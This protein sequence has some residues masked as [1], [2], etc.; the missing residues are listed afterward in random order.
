MT[1][2]PPRNLRLHLAVLGA[3]AVGLAAVAGSA[4]ELYGVGQTI[5]Y[6]WPA[7]IPLALDG[8]AVV[9]TALVTLR[10]DRHALA[11]LVA[12]GVLS[13]ALQVGAVLLPLL[14]REITMAAAAVAGLSILV[15]LAV[16]GAAITA[17]HLVAR[18]TA[19]DA[20]PAPAEASPVVPEPVAPPAPVEPAPILAPAPEPAPV[21]LAASAEVRPTP[22]RRPPRPRTDTA[23][24]RPRTRTLEELVPIAE[25]V[26]GDLQERGLPLSRRNL[27]DG[28]KDAGA[29]VGTTR[30]TELLE[31]LQSAQAPALALVDGGQS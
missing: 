3:A 10:R 26:A 16:L 11:A 24:P 8:L 18:Y 9:A 2:T 19:E 5:G 21:E 4:R 6:G 20:T 31:R 25:K 14:G 1:T 27:Q 22:R 29:G 28:L 30:A 15:H 13:G 12:S 23:K 17:I 7:A